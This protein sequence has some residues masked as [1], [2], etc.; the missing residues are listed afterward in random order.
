MV[1]AGSVGGHLPRPNSGPSE[2]PA[3]SALPAPLTF[4]LPSPHSFFEVTA[5]SNS[6]YAY[7][8][9]ELRLLGEA[10]QQWE[11]LGPVSISIYRRDAWI[12][13][14]ALQ[15]LTRHPTAPLQD[16]VERVGRNI[17]RN[18]CSGRE[19]L[20]RLAETGWDP[21]RDVDQVLPTTVAAAAVASGPAADLWPSEDQLLTAVDEAS[22]D[23]AVHPGW[24]GLMGVLPS[25]RRMAERV[26]AARRVLALVD[27]QAPAL[28]TETID[29]GTSD[30]RWAGVGLELSNL[31]TDLHSRWAQAVFE[32]AQQAHLAL[33]VLA[34]GKVP[35]AN[36]SL[37]ED[38]QPPL[39]PDVEPLPEAFADVELLTA[40]LAQ[41]GVVRSAQKQFDEAALVACDCDYRDECGGGHSIPEHMIDKAAELEEKM[42]RWT[43]YLSTYADAV[44]Y[45]LATTLRPRLYAQQGSHS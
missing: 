7:P 33:A 29:D 11:D 14:S 34:A 37:P 8:S 24:G 40:A 27:A 43:E 39:D 45:S 26:I 21:D 9:E 20:D 31:T 41:F 2:R 5:M 28:I 13:M 19:D 35:A 18:L 42:G 25:L 23:P 10:F 15:L 30:M 16:V 4:Y 36:G 6:A 22:I 1:G 17:Q 44:T 38:P 3:G 32:Y 12:A